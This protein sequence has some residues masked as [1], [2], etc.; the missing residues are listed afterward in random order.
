MGREYYL[1]ATKKV[2]EQKPLCISIDFE[3]IYN[4]YLLRLNLDKNYIVREEALFKSYK[5]IR[6]ILSK[7]FKNNNLTFLQLVSLQKKFQI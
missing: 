3:D 4:D 2:S 6:K 1:R 5:V 7:Y